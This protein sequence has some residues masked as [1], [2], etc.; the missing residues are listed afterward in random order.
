VTFLQYLEFG[1]LGFTLGMILLL[2][3]VLKYREGISYMESVFWACLYFGGFAPV[4]LL[5]PEGMTEHL[6]LGLFVGLLWYIIEKERDR[7]S[8]KIFD[9]E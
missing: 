8:G 5:E 1:V 7:S 6:E 9:S 4:F 3:V 2:A